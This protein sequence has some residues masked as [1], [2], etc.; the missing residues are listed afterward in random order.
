VRSRFVAEHASEGR[1]AGIENKLRQ[2]GLGDKMLKLP[3]TSNFTPRRSRT[4]SCHTEFGAMPR[5]ELVENR[6]PEE[7][8]SI[9]AS[10]AEVS[11]PE[12]RR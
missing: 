4:Q 10:S 9:S 8:R 11:V 5:L 1:P 7:R 3:E 2:A 6:Y 12:N